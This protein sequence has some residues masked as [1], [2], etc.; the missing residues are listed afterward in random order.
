MLFVACASAMRVVP[1]GELEKRVLQDIGGA[2]MGKQLTG[3]SLAAT[4]VQKSNG[5]FMQSQCKHVCYEYQECVAN[6]CRDECKDQ[7]ECMDVCYSEAS[8]LFYEFSPQT[9]HPINFVNAT[10][11]VAAS[12]DQLVRE[13]KQDPLMEHVSNAD[14]LASKIVTKSQECF[15]F[16]KCNHVC[17]EYQE[18]V[19]NF[20]GD[21]CE[22]QKDCVDACYTQA[23]ELFY[24][25]SPKVRQPVAFTNATVKRASFLQ[26]KAPKD[27]SHGY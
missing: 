24:R 16:S 8:E 3:S 17:Y 9:R 7:K 15:T 26:N 4:I 1:T 5:C 13:M 18:C 2:D 20:C 14:Q 6:F 11:F 22:H 10:L 27:S 19:H 21:Q 23:S 25:F 12:P